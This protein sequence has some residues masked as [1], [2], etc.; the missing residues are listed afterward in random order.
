MPKD[1]VKGFQLFI[2]QLSDRYRFLG[3]VHVTD[4]QNFIKILNDGYLQCR[5]ELDSFVDAAEQDV[6]DKAGNEKSCVRFYYYPK[7]PT[8]HNNE[9]IKRNNL[10]P[11]MPIPVCMV[12][13]S[14]L[15]YQDFTYFTDGNATHGLSICGDTYN[16]FTQI[17]WQKVFHRTYFEPHEREEIIRKRNAELLSK[18]PVS[19][20]GYLAKI[21]FRSESDRRMAELLAR[22]DFFPRDFEYLYS[23]NPNMFHNLPDRNYLKNHKVLNLDCKDAKM[24]CEFAT[25][26]VS[27]YTHGISIFNKEG[28]I[29]LNKNVELECIDKQRRSW[30]F[31]FPNPKMIDGAIRFIYTIENNVVAQLFKKE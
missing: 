10:A 18:K 25:N 15:I 4:F 22:K 14:K 17:D 21:I 24:E 20:K 28:Q 8:F 6:I 9:G 7:T 26:N 31:N 19:L 27:I 30:S 29:I 13:D 1:N 2:K 3:P 23:V 11:H 16:F 5:G 12:F